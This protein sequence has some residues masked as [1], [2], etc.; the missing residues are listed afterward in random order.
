MDEPIIAQ[1]GPYGL[2]LDAG[3]YF[4]MPVRKIVPAT[5]L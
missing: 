5:L 4:W 1:R 2:D 3:D